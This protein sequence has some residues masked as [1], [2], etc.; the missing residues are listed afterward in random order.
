MADGEGA[1]AERVE[2]GR[3]LRVE[4]GRALTGSV[5]LVLSPGAAALAGAM[6]EDD[7]EVEPYALDG[8]ASVARL[9]RAPRLDLVLVDD[10][11]ATSEELA[12]AVWALRSLDPWRLAVVAPTVSRYLGAILPPMCEIASPRRYVPVRESAAPRS[13]RRI[14]RPDRAGRPWSADEEASLA[15]MVRE[16]TPLRE[17][18]ARLER[19]RGAV[20]SRIAAMAVRPEPLAPASAP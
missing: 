15:D 19:T 13:A 7:E 2:L 12:A 16:R 11:G 4:L 14:P 5:V 1:E 9:A 3:A 10:G 6:A 18:A 8:F 20:A 17:I